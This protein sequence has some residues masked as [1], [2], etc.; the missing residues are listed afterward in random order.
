MN[1]RPDF[2]DA[3]SSPSYEKLATEAAKTYIFLFFIFC[4]IVAYLDEPTLGLWWAAILVGGLF[5]SSILV[6]A[7]MTG[8]KLLLATKVGINPLKSG[9][10]M[11]YS[12][13]DFVGY[14]ALWFATRYTINALSA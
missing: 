9:G 12:A 11:F 4:G 8:I 13:L 1:E 6:A 3:V 2:K 7:P 10:R 14:A 5:A